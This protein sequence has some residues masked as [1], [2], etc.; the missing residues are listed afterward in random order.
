MKEFIV[1]L[2]GFIL[3]FFCLGLTFPASVIVGVSCIIF[4]YA[5]APF[6]LI[7]LCTW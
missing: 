2:L 1:F 7:V 5:L 6:A 3:S 4:W